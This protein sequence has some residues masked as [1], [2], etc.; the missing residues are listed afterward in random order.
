M[1]ASQKLKSISAVVAVVA[2]ITLG[3]ALI[4]AIWF[5]FEYE[6]LWKSIATCF[7]V[8][9]LAGFLHVVAQGMVQGEEKN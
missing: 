5:E 3:V 9:L 1:T 2:A 8:L 7:V 6:I 4:L